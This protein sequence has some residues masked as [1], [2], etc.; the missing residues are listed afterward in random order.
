MEKPSSLSLSD[1]DELEPPSKTRKVVAPMDI[2]TALQQHPF[3]TKG[4]PGSELT[5]G[6]VLD[7]PPEVVKF[8]VLRKNNGTEPI[9]RRLAELLEGKVKLVIRSSNFNVSRPCQDP[10]NAQFSTG[11]NP[12]LLTKVGYWSPP[13]ISYKCQASKESAALCKQGARTTKLSQCKFLIELK[14]HQNKKACNED[15]NLKEFLDALKSAYVASALDKDS[16]EKHQDWEAA[17]GAMS[18]WLDNL[19]WV[20][21]SFNSEH[22]GHRPHSPELENPF[23]T[24][25]EL[26]PWV[27]QNR[28]F[29]ANNSALME[30][31]GDKIKELAARD[32]SFNAPS[33]TR[34]V[35]FF[36]SPV[37]I[38][39]KAF[40][41]F[42]KDLRNAIRIAADKKTNAG[43]SAS[44]QI[45]QESTPAT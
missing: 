36:A 16:A 27:R 12:K 25:A 24:W 15:T 43:N 11:E 17:R 26:L 4:K 23:K 42:S 1:S 30:M 41:F 37:L 18:D 19:P 33:F 3:E 29:G 2:K 9:N 28:G 14:K 38:D 10:R 34:N 6:T 35:I 31:L 44:A 5:V 22:V 21:S 45:I 13:S 20:V 40:D 7:L 39:L 8:E 32:G